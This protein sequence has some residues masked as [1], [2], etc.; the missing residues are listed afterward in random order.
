MHEPD[1]HLAALAPQLAE[2]V[3]RM[4]LDLYSAKIAWEIVLTDPERTPTEQALAEHVLGHIDN[5]LGETND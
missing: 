1:V 2:E 5:V 3:L 4:R